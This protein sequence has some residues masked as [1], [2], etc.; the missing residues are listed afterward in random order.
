MGSIGIA[1]SFVSLCFS[2]LGMGMIA[3][4]QAHLKIGK[5]GELSTILGH[6]S[7]NGIK[8]AVEV[9]ASRMDSGN[10][11]IDLTDERFETL[12]NDLL[13]GGTGAAETILGCSFP[14]AL[15]DTWE[16]MSW[17]SSTECRNE[18]VQN[19][20]PYLTGV[21]DLEI[22]SVGKHRSFKPARLSAC[23]AS[24]KITAGRIPLPA[25]PFL[26]NKTMSPN[27]TSDFL[28]ENRITLRSPSDG[29]APVRMTANGDAVL[30]S[31]ALPLLSE[32]LKIDLIHPGDLTN[33][34]LRRSLGLEESDEDI[35]N[36]V[37]L[38]RDCAELGGLYIEGDV[39]E[40]ITAIDGEYQAICIRLDGKEWTLKYAPSL[41]RTFFDTPDGQEAFDLLPPGIVFV[42]GKIM[43]LGGGIVDGSG[44]IRIV[45]DDPV[46]SI[47]SGLQLTLVSSDKITLTSHLISQGVRWRDGLPYIK[48]GSSQ[49]IIYASGA[50]FHDGSSREGGI[51]IAE[52][53]PE[54]TAIQASLTAGGSGLSIQGEGKNI[55]ILGSLQTTDIAAKGNALTISPG[56]NAE[57]VLQSKLFA[58][59]TPNPILL[60]SSFRI[61]EW[62]EY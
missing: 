18:S 23:S 32:A 38:I 20:G 1:T 47:L 39:D 7:E 35:P 2:V 27:E 21:F 19:K 41:G 33:P 57:S 11:L 61:G 16:E 54:N 28:T 60:V 8:Q 45:Q 4:S 24:M 62:K 10:T 3:L 53:A 46:P 15:R 37:Y 34:L 29:L 56:R 55:E 48:E 52:E 59:L 6:A 17:A 42:N 30:P 43:S 58:P 9:L 44:E 49:V 13:S 25:V 36:G 31:D 40:M 51:D 5:A 12:R 26:V 50:D 14:L 22:Q